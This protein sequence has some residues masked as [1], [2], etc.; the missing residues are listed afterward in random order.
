MTAH[1]PEAE[2]APPLAGIQ[3]YNTLA[4]R[5]EPLCPSR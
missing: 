5:K 1:Q 2:T 4:R 3:V